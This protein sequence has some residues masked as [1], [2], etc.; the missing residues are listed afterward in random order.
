MSELFIS[1]ALVATFASVLLGAAAAELTFAERRRT[2]RL[3]EAQVDAVGANLRDEDL[4][5]SFLDRVF[6]PL[7]K[8]MGSLALRVTP[9]GMLRRIERKLVLAGSPA[10][11]DGP[12]VAAFKLIG[13]LG[14][15]TFPL[16]VGTLG[17]SSPSTLLLPIGLFTV[18]GFFAPDAILSGA[19]RR[20]Q[21]IIQ[22]ALPDTLDLLTISVEAGLGFDG[23][24]AHVIQHVPGPL[25]NEIGRM[26]QEV[27]LGMARSDALRRL[28]DRT[29]I[30]EL[31][32]FI[33]AV[34][35][36]DIFGV[37]VARVLRA[38]ARELR[39]KRRQ[40]AER[41]AMQTPV[42][43]LFPLIFCVLPALFTVIIGPGAV[44]IFN[45]FF[46]G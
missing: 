34:I 2:I 36:A 37:G 3:L 11:W 21:D 38:Q 19:A 4:S 30:D 23:A 44:R 1:F 8:G 6:F 12:R 45:N 39:I 15:A 31:R 29:D 35:Q 17:G 9:V 20:R 32:G 33:L 43:I 42:K 16:L 24:L 26:L 46:G 40:R 28:A 14:G 25:S 18:S 10:G 41:R 22:K 5:R 27:Q 7:V 13:L